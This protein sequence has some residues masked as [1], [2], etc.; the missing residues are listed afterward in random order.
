VSTNGSADGREPLRPNRS[1]GGG[2]AISVM[3]CGYLG[4]VRAACMAALGHDVVGFDVDAAKI[5][6]G[7]RQ[8]ISWWGAERAM[9]SAP[10]GALV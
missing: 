2:L 9:E 4:A 3:G 5:N 8:L 7:F 6:D 1:E 10:V